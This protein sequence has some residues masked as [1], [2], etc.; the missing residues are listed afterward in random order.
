MAEDE[1]TTIQVRKNAREELA[2]LASYGD[3]MADIVDCLITSYKKT[4]RGK[5]LGG[6][7]A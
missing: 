5:K 2:K 3:S 7:K 1:Y 4:E 6:E